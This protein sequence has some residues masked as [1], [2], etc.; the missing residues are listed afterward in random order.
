M[1]QILISKA[2]SPDV[3][4]VKESPDQIPRNGELRIKVEAAAVN[5]ADILGRMGRYKNAPAFPYVPGFEIAGTVDVV[6]QGVSGF[7]EGDHVLAYVNNGGYSDTICVPYLQAFKRLDWMSAPDGAALP[8]DFLTAYV[9]LVI[10]GSLHTSDLVLIHDAADGIGIAALDICRL[11]G[12]KTFGI[13]SSDKHDLLRERGLDYPIDKR[14]RDY[15]RVIRE[16]TDG[17]GVDI[18]LS[19]LSRSYW[20]KNYRVLASTGK[21]IYLDSASLE[22]LKGRRITNYLRSIMAKH[23]YAPDGLSRDNKSVAGFNLENLWNQSELVQKWMQQI[24]SWYDEALFRPLLDKTFSFS[25]VK[26]AHH[27]ALK[28]ESIGKILLTP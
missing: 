5:P 3:L 18:V 27:Y 2:G 15:E 20:K 4:V 17:R 24:I 11:I 28:Q 22:D 6:T 10:M 13:A 7:R 8:V 19:R 1:R 9:T 12:V 25:Q 16:K 26:D 14:D 21:L 23:S